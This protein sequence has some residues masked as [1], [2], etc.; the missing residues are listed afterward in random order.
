LG[1]AEHIAHRNISLLGVLNNF[2][3][4]IVGYLPAAFEFAAE[5]TYPEPEAS[6][7]GVMTFGCQILCVIYTLAYGWVFEPYGDLASNLF[8]SGSLVVATILTLFAKSDLRRQRA[9]AHRCD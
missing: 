9:E 5:L 7:A 1:T 2:S 3:F 6:S 8:M 4:F